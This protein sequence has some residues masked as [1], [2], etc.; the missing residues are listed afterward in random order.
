[1]SSELNGWY[2]GGWMVFKG[3]Y[4]SAKESLDKQVKGINASL[5]AEIS[6]CGMTL[7]GLLAVKPYPSV[8]V[9]NWIMQ[10]DVSG[11]GLRTCT[12]SGLLYLKNESGS[13]HSKYAFNLGVFMFNG[14]DEVKHIYL[15][16]AGSEGY[17]YT[18]VLSGYGFKYYCNSRMVKPVLVYSEMTNPFYDSEE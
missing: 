6:Y 17:R 7:S 3:M 5:S 10:F 14:V 12:G 11:I 8:S 15:I 18:A 13:M 1:M 9:L 4:A 2:R 16:T